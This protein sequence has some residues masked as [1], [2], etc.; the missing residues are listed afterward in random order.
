MN[1]TE[2]PDLR[3][4]DDMAAYDAMAK[5]DA[6][7]GELDPTAYRA[8]VF[9]A[10]DMPRPAEQDGT[11]AVR[12]AGAARPGQPEPYIPGAEHLQMRWRCLRQVVTGMQQ[13]SLTLAAEFPASCEADRAD[14]LRLVLRAML[15]IEANFPGA[16]S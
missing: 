3:H 2:D 4:D 11:G 1:R 6:M 16:T 15:Q 7:F 12:S 8:K 10:P 13:A 5:T 14:T 9:G